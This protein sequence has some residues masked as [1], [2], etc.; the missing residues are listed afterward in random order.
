MQRLPQ[1]RSAAAS[2]ASVDSRGSHAKESLDSHAR[3]SRESRESRDSD[4][5]SVVHAVTPP[6]APG[7]RFCFR[8]FFGL[9]LCFC[10]SV[11]LSLLSVLSRR[12]LAFD[13]R[14]RVG[15]LQ[16][17]RSRRGPPARPLAPS[18]AVTQT[19]A[20]S[21]PSLQ[22]AQ[23]P[24]VP[25]KPLAQPLLPSADAFAINGNPQPYVKMH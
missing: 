18:A 16:G 1:R 17:H 11:T 4:E 22:A 8:F 9:R 15:D 14:A 23:R 19:A 24:F 20:H 3:E 5:F 6:T 25:H 21:P 2:S 7:S 12:S 10:L 13:S